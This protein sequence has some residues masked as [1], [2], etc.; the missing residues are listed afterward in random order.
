MR[1]P[2]RVALVA[3][4]TLIAPTLAAQQSDIE[5]SL[6]AVRAVLAVPQQAPPK[7]GPSRMHFAYE[8]DVQSGCTVKLTSRWKTGL[9]EHRTV[10]EA[11]LSAVSPDIEIHR[12]DTLVI[13]S[14][15]TSSG[16]SE[17]HRR[18]VRGVVT[19]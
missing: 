4:A 14:A 11:D 18:V 6:R 15:S 8:L 5:T 2:V 13:V 10:V 12:A 9:V 19:N 7:S 3:A 17:L 1:L 16:R